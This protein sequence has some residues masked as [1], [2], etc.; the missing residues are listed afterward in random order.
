MSVI[1]LAANAMI[2]TTNKNRTIMMGKVRVSGC[3]SEP[4]GR[5]SRDATTTSLPDQVK[6]SDACDS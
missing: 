5:E 3:E 2:H 6:A 1:Q 4:T